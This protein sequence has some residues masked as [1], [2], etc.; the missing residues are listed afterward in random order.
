MA[1]KLETYFR[2]F[3][4]EIRLTDNQIQELKV[5]H[6][7]LRGRLMN[8]YKLKD[9]IVGTFLQGSYKRSTAV[10][11]KNGNRSDVDIIIVTNLDKNKI[12]PDNAIE[13]FRP[14]LKKYYDGKFRKQG[15]SW[16]IEMSHVDLDIVPTS[17][18]SEIEDKS[19]RDYFIKSDEDIESIIN[20]IKTN[21]I[22]KLYMENFIKIKRSNSKWQDD[23]L[24]IPDRKIKEWGK[25]HPIEQI[26]WTLEKNKNCNKFLKQISI[27]LDS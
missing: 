8:D 12:E 25:T 1:L 15:R 6:E 16:G 7:T 4:R 26:R 23:P 14:F 2:D 22:K 21:N 13:K 3:L 5:A 11:P 18:P 9:I 20:E 10:R 17:A 27:R 19:L 24:Y